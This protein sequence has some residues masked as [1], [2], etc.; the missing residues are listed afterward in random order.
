MGRGAR[1]RR[2]RGF[3]AEWAV[4]ESRDGGTHVD[5]NEP[6]PTGR[7]RFEP[8]PRRVI[9]GRELRPGKTQKYVLSLSLLRRRTR[10][11]LREAGC[12]KPRRPRRCV[13]RGVF[14]IKSRGNRICRDR[15]SN[16]ELATDYR[17]T[18]Q[19]PSPHSGCRS[20]SIDD[21]FESRN[22][23]R[24]FA[25]LPIVQGRATVFVGVVFRHRPSPKHDSGQRR[26]RSG[27]SGA[28]R[29]PLPVDRCATFVMGI[30][31]KKVSLICRL[32]SRAWRFDRR[33]SGSRGLCVSSQRT[34]C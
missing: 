29:A 23:E 33:R 27:S 6:K 2:G 5:A 24:W 10:L 28:N 19:R 34:G 1:T 12:R 32:R 18:A 21:S 20:R 13:C 14:A 30:S 16:R 15:H 17:I 4:A 9:A 8:L 25:T 26:G 3:L 7:R 31:H 22:R 11:L